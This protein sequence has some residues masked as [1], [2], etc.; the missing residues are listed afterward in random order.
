MRFC[1]A[2]V[3]FAAIYYAVLN[4]VTPLLGV[5]LPFGSDL[6]VSGSLL[7]LVGTVAYCFTFSAISM[8]LASFTLHL[9]HR[10]AAKAASAS[11]N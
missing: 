3:Y 2:A 10:N 6:S 1:L 7:L 9:L 11:P 8:Q 4:F 5:S